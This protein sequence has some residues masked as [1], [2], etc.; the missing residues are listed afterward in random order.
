MRAHAPRSRSA[1]TSIMGSRRMAL[2]PLELHLRV[3][4]T[5]TGT[6]QLALHTYGIFFIWASVG[7]YALL[8]GA[9]LTAATRTAHGSLRGRLFLPK[10]SPDFR[11]LPAASSEPRTWRHTLRAATRTS[12]RERQQGR[13][14]PSAAQLNRLIQLLLGWV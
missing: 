8:I 3:S 1:A 5:V 12:D 9:W 13:A 10:P 6:S 4:T 2:A 11:P 14:Q 7:L